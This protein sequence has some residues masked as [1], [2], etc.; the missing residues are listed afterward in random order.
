[1]LLLGRDLPGTGVEGDGVDVD[2]AHAITQRDVVPDLVERVGALDVDQGRSLER[3]VEERRGRGAHVDDV[4]LARNGDDRCR[5]PEDEP[6]GGSDREPGAD[7]RADPVVD[8]D[9][10]AP[11]RPPADAA[12]EPSVG[13]GDVDDLVTA[14]ARNVGELLVT[15][16]LEPRRTPE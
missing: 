15:A 1:G 6:G 2:A 16:M 3:L 12:N 13:A 5:K 11:I 14:G 9:H 8:D 10:L 7:P 4:A